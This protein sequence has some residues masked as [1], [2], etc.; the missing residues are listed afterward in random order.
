MAR[1]RLSDAAWDCI[2][3]FFPEPKATGRPPRDRR[4]VLDGILWVL[5][6]GSPWR[7]LPDEFGPWQT[8][9]RLFDAWNDDGTLVKILRALQAAHFDAGLIDSEL[10][11]IDGSIVRAARCSA[12]GGKKGIPTSRPIM[13]SAAAGAGFRRKSTCSATPTATH[14]TSI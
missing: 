1:N 7:D 12:G 13:L 6:T 5:R 8:V 14:C 11:C 4:M 10:W 2:Q 3:D 9:W